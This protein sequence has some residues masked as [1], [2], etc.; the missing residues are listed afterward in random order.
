[1][2]EDLKAAVEGMHNC[3]A[4]GYR[5]ERVV[6]TID[7]QVAWHGEVTIFDVD[8]PQTNTC[9]TWSSPVEGSENRKFY[10]VLKIPPIETAAD[11]VRASIISDFRSSG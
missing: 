7:G 1:M 5:M 3:V 4:S 9:F 6:E 2:I 8:H 11:A 10:A